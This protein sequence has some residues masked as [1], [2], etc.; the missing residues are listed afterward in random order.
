MIIFVAG[1]HG[2]GKSFLCKKYASQHNIIHKSASELIKD[3][4]SSSVPSNK[5][6]KDIDKNQEIL[7]HAVNSIR[8][9]NKSLL[10]DGHF[11]LINSS[12]KFSYIDEKVYS[13]LNIDGIILFE[14]SEDIVKKRLFQRDK[15]LVNYDINKMINLERERALLISKKYSIPIET[16]FS[17]TQKELETAINQ[18]ENAR[19]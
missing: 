17:P 9:Q 16:L 10:L 1:V 18:L 19:L 3:F 8:I 13:D 15:N 12:G 11:V 14:N 5:H 4:D 2:V 6:T 7:I